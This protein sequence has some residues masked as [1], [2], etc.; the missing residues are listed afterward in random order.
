MK[1]TP[2]QKRGSGIVLAGLLGVFTGHFLP[3][4][5]FVSIIE[6]IA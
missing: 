4:D 3:P 5:V 6:A 1:L 2:Q